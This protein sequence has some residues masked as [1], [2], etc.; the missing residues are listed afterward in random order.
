M[1]FVFHGMAQADFDAWVKNAKSNTQA[2]TRSRYLELARPSE[3]EPAQQFGSVDPELYHAIL[4]MCVEPAAT[5]MDAMPG[6]DMPG[7]SMPASEMPTHST[8]TQNHSHH[9]H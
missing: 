1:R 9:A 4:N 8:S 7:M 6:M 2:L 3:K 5:C